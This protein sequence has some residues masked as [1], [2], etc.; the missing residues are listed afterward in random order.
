MEVLKSLNLG[1]RFLLEL[2]LLGA[3]GYIGYA[4]TTTTGMR[5]ALAVVLPLAAATVWGLF[6]APKAQLPLP[7]PARIAAEL[8]LFAIACILLAHYGKPSLAIGFAAAVLINETLLII[9]R[10]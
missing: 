10:Q 6:I 3:F 8:M 4:L 7:L 5:Y 1:L 2:C 9:W